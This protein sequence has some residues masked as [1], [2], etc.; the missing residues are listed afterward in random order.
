MYMN[1]HGVK[2]I[3]CH[4]V[5][6]PKMMNS[7]LLYSSTQPTLMQLTTKSLG[8]MKH[9]SNRMMHLS[10]INENKQD[11]FPSKVYFSKIDAVVPYKQN[12]MFKLV[13]FQH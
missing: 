6:E 1:E 4:M 10:S 5:S 8:T 13:H 11:T 9:L 3:L 2:E 12:L 7:I